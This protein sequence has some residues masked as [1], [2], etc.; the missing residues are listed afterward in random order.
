MTE[1]LKALNFRIARGEEFPDACWAVASR[2]Q[3]GY[4]ELADAYDA[5]F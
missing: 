5:Q 4:T 2:F 3:V 1:A